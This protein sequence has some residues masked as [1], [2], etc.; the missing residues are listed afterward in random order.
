MGPEGREQIPLG[1]RPV[2]VGRH[3]TNTIF[4]QAGLASRFHCLIWVKQGKAW[5]KDLNSSNGTFVN[6]NPVTTVELSLRDIIKVG[7]TQI[8][9]TSAS[10][11]APPTMLLPRITKPRFGPRPPH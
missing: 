9:F 5:V 10:D 1:E 6:G 3:S 7:D 11:T 4:I 8:L 2:S